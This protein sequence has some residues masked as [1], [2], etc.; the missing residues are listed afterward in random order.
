MLLEIASSC[1][2]CAAIPVAAMFNDLNMA[3]LHC[4]QKQQRCQLGARSR[5]SKIP[6]FCRPFADSRAS[7]RGRF[8]FASEVWL[9]L[10]NAPSLAPLS[11]MPASSTV[12]AAPATEPSA[13]EASA[14]GLVST[15]HSARSQR[16][17]SAQSEFRMQAPFAQPALVTTVP[18]SAD[19]KSSSSRQ[20]EILRML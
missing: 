14:A 3:I 10:S 20:H 7:D 9:P 17:P 19:Q 16:K 1:V 15:T 2:S 4:Y 6:A 13:T 12:A 8:Q 18:P 5:T 11:T